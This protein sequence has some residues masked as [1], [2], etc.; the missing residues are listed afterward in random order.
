MKNKIEEK[1]VSLKFKIYEDGFMCVTSPD[2]KG[3]SLCA[4]KDRRGELF[5]DIGPTVRILLSANHDWPK[6]DKEFSDKLKEDL[7]PVVA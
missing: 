4:Q 1:T 3:L 2:I 6:D 7:Q 5:L